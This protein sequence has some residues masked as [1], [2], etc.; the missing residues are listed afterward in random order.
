MDWQIS[1]ESSNGKI[2]LVVSQTD[3]VEGIHLRQWG[4]TFLA[5]GPMLEGKRALHNYTYVELLL[6]HTFLWR[7]CEVG[8]ENRKN[9]IR[10]FGDCDFFL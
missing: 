10:S 5:Q 9:F 6:S 1:R 8:N 3:G 4:T 7:T 2:E